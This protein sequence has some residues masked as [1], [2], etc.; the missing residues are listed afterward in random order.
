MHP[1]PL[2]KPAALETL[3]TE[4]GPGGMVSFFSLIDPRLVLEL[5][6]IAKIRITEEEVEMLHQC[7]RAGRF[8][9][10]GGGGT[11][12]DSAP[13]PCETNDRRYEPVNF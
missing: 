5:V 2:L 13:I 10:A 1:L 8:P 7:M 9:S 3:D 11:G 6:E 12:G 4:D